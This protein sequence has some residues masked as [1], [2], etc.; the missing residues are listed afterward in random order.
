MRLQRLAF[1]LLS[2]TT[3]LSQSNPQA[4]VSTLSI[5]VCLSNG[6]SGGYGIGGAGNGTGGG[7]GGGTGYEQKAVYWVGRIEKLMYNSLPTVVVTSVSSPYGLYSQLGWYADQASGYLLGG[8]QTTSSQMSLTYC[9]SFCDGTPFFAV[10][11]G[12]Y[13]L[14]FT[15]IRGVCCFMIRF[16]RSSELC[17]TQENFILCFFQSKNANTAKV[18]HV[19]V[20]PVVPAAQW[21]A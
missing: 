1:G 17:S 6:S 21:L 12:K 13:S 14:A 20:A 11:N 15:L 10:E 2:A 4:A 7:G 18:I 9:A 16:R 3:A 5:G 8:S 19:C